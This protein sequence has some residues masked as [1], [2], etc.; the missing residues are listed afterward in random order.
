MS[1]LRNCLYPLLRLVSS[2]TL[3]ACLSSCGPSSRGSPV[4]RHPVTTLPPRLTLP[5][6]PF[7]LTP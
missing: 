2:P 1:H 5:R 7:L 6:I 4:I 3:C